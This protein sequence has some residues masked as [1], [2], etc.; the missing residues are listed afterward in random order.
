MDTEG[1]YENQTWI[2]YIETSCGMQK[3]PVDQLIQ[4]VLSTG[5]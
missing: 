5:L 4:M 3:P 1:D 2:N